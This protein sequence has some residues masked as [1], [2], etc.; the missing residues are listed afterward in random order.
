MSEGVYARGRDGRER[1]VH[2]YIGG[3]YALEEIPEFFGIG[4]FEEK[5]GNQSD[6][7]FTRSEAEQLKREIDARGFDFDEDFTQLCRDLY[8]FI[9]GEDLDEVR[10]RA[11]F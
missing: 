3:D 10:F 11:D 8:S 1:L 5:G 2:E 9:A 6:L 4:R 7:V